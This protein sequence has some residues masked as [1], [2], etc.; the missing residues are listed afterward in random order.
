MRGVGLNPTFHL[1][2][3]LIRPRH[4][5]RSARL[6]SPTRGECR[7]GSPLTAEGLM[8]SQ[9]FSAILVIIIGVGGCVA[10][11]WGAN[12]LLD[13]IFP[14]RG[15]KGGAAIDNLRR[16]GIIRP[17]LFIGP[18]LIILV[19]YLIYPVYQTVILSFHDRGG[20]NF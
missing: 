2:A 16:Q 9:I 10:Y 12:K 17:W 6:P 11:F 13:V 15:V 4:S 7:S 5:L 18:A 20:E 8:G 19:V 1:P 3:P 14:S